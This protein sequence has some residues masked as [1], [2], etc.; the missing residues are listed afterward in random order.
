M[1]V[2][3]IDTKIRG[4]VP[5]PSEQD[6]RRAAL[7]IAHHAQDAEDC[8]EL[9]RMCGLADPGFHWTGSVHTGADKRRKISKEAS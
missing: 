3:R 7:T 9:L 1:S 6:Q 2:D 4:P 8:L 5:E